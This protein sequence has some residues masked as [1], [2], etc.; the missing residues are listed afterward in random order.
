MASKQMTLTVTTDLL[1]IEIDTSN[2]ALRLH[3][4]VSVPDG[5]GGNVTVQ[6]YKEDVTALLNASDIAAVQQLVTRAQAWIDTK[7]PA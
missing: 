6:E 5:L 2:Q 7:M 4:V 1:A 3:G